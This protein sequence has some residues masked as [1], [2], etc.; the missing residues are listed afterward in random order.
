MN[1]HVFACRMLCQFLSSSWNHK[2]HA[3]PF[4]VYASIYVI[5]NEMHEIT[6]RTKQV[7]QNSSHF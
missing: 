5:S 6:P 3:A 4:R 1:L 2:R 7:T